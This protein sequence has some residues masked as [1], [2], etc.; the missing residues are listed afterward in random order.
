M[1]I[2]AHHHLWGKIF[3]SS[4]HVHVFVY[5]LLG[6][7]FDYWTSLVFDPTLSHDALR[8]CCL[9]SFFHP[10]LPSHLAALLPITN[11]Q[12]RQHLDALRP[13]RQQ[14][15]WV[16]SMPRPRSKPSP[17][18]LGGVDVFEDFLYGVCKMSNW[19]LVETFAPYVDPSEESSAG[20]LTDSVRTTGLFFGT[21]SSTSSTVSPHITGS[22]RSFAVT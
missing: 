5:T 12:K 21:L 17:H 22:C 7:S 3:P 8:I 16:S 14:P 11:H 2:I 13:R 1:P 6:C 15:I 4:H 20:H 10:T 18:F 9:P 19:Q